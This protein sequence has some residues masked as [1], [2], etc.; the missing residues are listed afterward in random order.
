M[1]VC[2]GNDKDIWNKEN[3]W[4]LIIF[5]ENNI[6]Q[7]GVIMYI[8]E[9]KNKKWLLVS[10]NPTSH[11]T[12]LVTGRRIYHK[13]LQA[14]FTICKQLDFGGVLIP[15]DENIQSNRRVIQEEILKQN[16][17]INAIPSFYFG[18]YYLGSDQKYYVEDVYVIENSL[19]KKLSRFFK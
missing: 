4:Q 13:L 7:G 5:D 12:S 8:V 6:A 19:I 18:K 11:L 2:I 10:I 14:L 16:Y 1:G 3:Y 9:Y 17:V 15:L